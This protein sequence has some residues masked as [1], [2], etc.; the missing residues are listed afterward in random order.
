MLSIKN[1]V[2]FTVNLVMDYS[3]LSISIYFIIF[4][5]IMT[6]NIILIILKNKNTII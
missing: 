3:V 2:A 4:F 1:D 6:K 5:V